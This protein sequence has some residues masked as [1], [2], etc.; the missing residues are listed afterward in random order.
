MKNDTLTSFKRA[1]NNVGFCLKKHSPEI[2]LVCGIVGTVAGTVLACKATLKLNDI[3]EETNDDVKKIKDVEA[4]ESIVEYTSDDAKKDLTIVYTKTALKIAKLYS[5]ALII[6]GLSMASLVGSHNILS[7]RNMALAAAYAT[8]DGGF[9][10]YRN[11][12]IEKFGDKVDKELRFGTKSEKIEEKVVDEKGKEKKVKKDVD[13]IHDIT[14]FS[15]YSDFAKIFDESSEYWEDDSSFNLTFLKHQE[16]YANDLLKAK[17]HLFLN[18][19]YDMLGIKR[20]KAGQVVGWIYDPKNEDHKGDNY[21]TFGIYNVRSQA[22]RD[23]INGYEDCVIL[24]FNVDGNIIN[25]FK[26]GDI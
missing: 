16:S 13:V 1:I 20:T 12:V 15:G 26:A 10:K 4:N 24:D 5:P 14:D 17:G 21:V 19:V 3:L 23:F 9:K 22:N 7:K 2:L 11:R 8:V 25:T 6:G 18:E